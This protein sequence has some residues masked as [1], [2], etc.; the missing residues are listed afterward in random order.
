MAICEQ[1]KA[2]TATKLSDGFLVRVANPEDL[3]EI[4]AIFN[5]SIGGKQAT[6]HLALVDVAERQ[7]WFDDHLQ[8]PKRP[9]VVVT[10]TSSAQI[11][12]WGSFS[13]L[14]ARPAYHISSEISIY[15]HQDYQNQG[16]GRKLL[17]WMLDTAPSLGINNV[18]ALIFGHNAPSLALFNKFGFSQW[19]YLPK[20][21][22]MDGFLA[23]VVILG[24]T[25]GI[26]DER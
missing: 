1:G 19:G 20:V 16:L 14:Y 4:L 2:L 5:Q 3:P 17:A 13:D 25:L 23:D 22:D 8:N 26:N 15:L 7:A 10:Q 6:A 12:A 24:L 11:I 18:I 21:C 9:I